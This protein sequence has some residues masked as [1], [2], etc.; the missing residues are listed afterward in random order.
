MYSRARL[1]IWHFTY[2]IFLRYY[3]IPLKLIGWDLNPR[4]LQSSKSCESSTTLHQFERKHLSRLVLRP[5]EQLAFLWLGPQNIPWPLEWGVKA[6]P[7]RESPRYYKEV[8]FST[9]DV[10]S[11]SLR[12]FLH[13]TVF[14]R[15][16][17]W[18]SS[19]SPWM[20][21]TWEVL[22]DTYV[23]FPKRHFCSWFLK[24]QRNGLLVGSVSEVCD[25]WP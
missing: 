19:E 25:S 18:Q 10:V 2:I 13:L 14:L 16:I 17:P 22:W 20:N 12:W 15:W 1:C 7:Y 9:S 23:K 5:L 6:F 11:G 3:K 21:V 4:L 8:G 24:M